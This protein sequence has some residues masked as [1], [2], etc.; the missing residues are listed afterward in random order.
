MEKEM[1]VTTID[2][3]FDY[4]EDFDNWYKFDFQHGYNTLGYV[5][6]LAKTSDELSDDEN[7]REIE[8]AVDSIVRWNPLL[9]RKV[10]KGAKKAPV[11]ST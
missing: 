2:N 8:S 4:F 5:A 7:E 1:F 11:A 3:P 6:R 9:Y 10:V